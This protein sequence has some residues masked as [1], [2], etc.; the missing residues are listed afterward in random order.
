MLPPCHGANAN[1]HEAILP[2]CQHHVVVLVHVVEHFVACRPE[3]AY[4]TEVGVHTSAWH[5]L[6]G[7]GHQLSVDPIS[8]I[9]LGQ[10]K[11]S[12]LRYLM[13]VPLGRWDTSIILVMGNFSE[14]GALNTFVDS[15]NLAVTA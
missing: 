13:S 1:H 11:P 9:M 10:P 8:P 15:R 5:V 3:C 14:S 4:G 6:P 7:L 2:T 12:L